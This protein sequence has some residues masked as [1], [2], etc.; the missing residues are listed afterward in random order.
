MSNSGGAWH[1]GRLYT[2]G[3][4]EPTLYVFDVPPSGGVLTLVAT[5][6]VESAGQGIAFDRDVG[7]LYSIQRATKE[8]L[9]SRLGE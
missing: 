5:V 4:D 7:L 8:V 9:V 2:T 3:H 6:A 1:A